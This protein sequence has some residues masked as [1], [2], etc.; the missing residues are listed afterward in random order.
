MSHFTFTHTNTTNPICKFNRK[1]ENNGGALSKLGL[2][3]NIKQFHAQCQTESNDEEG[4]SQD[5]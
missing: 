4:K 5:R 1:T 2:D 3:C